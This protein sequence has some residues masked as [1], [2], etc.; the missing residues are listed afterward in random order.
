MKRLILP[1]VACFV[2]AS[3]VSAQNQSSPPEGVRDKLKLWNYTTRPDT[4]QADYRRLVETWENTKDKSEREKL[5]KDL[6]EELKKEFEA[7]M[8]VHEQEL[9]G[10]EDKVR[11]LRER[12]AL[13]K[14][15][16]NEIIDN[17]LQ[18]ILREAQGLGWGT[19]KADTAFHT[20]STISIAPPL[21]RTVPDLPYPG[22]VRNGAIYVDKVE[23]SS[24]DVNNPNLK[25]QQ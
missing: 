22:G 9:K 19:D 12:L 11:Q 20:Q 6:R 13:R 24:G 5:E 16:Q 8:A 14:E 7:R 4:A 10:L 17:R 1:L 25:Q 3:I 21:K 15:K 23:A 18:Q 2:V